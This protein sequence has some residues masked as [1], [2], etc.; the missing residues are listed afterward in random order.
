MGSFLTL[1]NELSEEKHALTKQETLLGRGA[2]AKSSSG[3]E[4]RRTAL[5]CSLQ[6]QVMGLVPCCLWPVVLTQGLVAAYHSAKMDSSE[7][8]SGRLLGHTDWHPLS[9]F[10]LFFLVPVGESLLVPRSLPGPPVV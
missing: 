2:Q 6:S 5:P 1:R 4:C 9:P 3:R 10:G 8:D 7:E